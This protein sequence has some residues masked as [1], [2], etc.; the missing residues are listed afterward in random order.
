MQEGDLTPA[1][2]DAGPSSDDPHATLVQPV[3]RCDQI[4]N[5]ERQVVD[6]TTTSAQIPGH[7]RFVRDRLEQLDSRGSRVQERHLDPLGGHRL[8]PADFEPQGFGPERQALLE[9]TDRD[10][11]VIDLGDHRTSSLATISPTA[12]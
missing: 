1:G 5:L 7:R 11:D 8:H 6:S 3:E 12:V 2:A 4:A 9:R 10:T